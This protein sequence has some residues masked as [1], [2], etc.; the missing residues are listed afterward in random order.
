MMTNKMYTFKELRPKE[1]EIICVRISNDVRD[2][3]YIG[4]IQGISFFSCL[5]NVCGTNRGTSCGISFI[6]L[7]TDEWCYIKN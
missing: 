2:F 3:V 5:G 6:P 1:N 7:E 4:Y